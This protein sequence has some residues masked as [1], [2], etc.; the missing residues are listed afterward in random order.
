MSVIERDQTGI[1]A[2]GLTKSYGSV[3]AVRG[4]DL[5]IAP[6]ETVALLGP[7]G[8]GKTTTIDMMLGLTRPDA[9]EVAVFGVPPATAVRSGW[10]GGM[11]QIGSLPDHLRVRELVSLVASYYPHPLRVDDVLALTGSATSRSAGRGSYPVG[12]PSGAL[13]RTALVANS[14]S[15]G[16]RRADRGHRRR[17]PHRVLAG[18]AGGRRAKGKTIVFATHYLEEADAFADRIVL[19]ARGRIVADGSRP[20]R[21][22]RRSAPE[23][24]GRRCRA[25]TSSRCAPCRV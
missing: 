17:G 24:S 11:L 18:H 15:L 8:A 19:M 20:P 14:R 4:I 7:N 13:C 3:Q 10:V 9:G 23:R 2:N 12:K 22:R 21:S 1:R 6:G 16:P 25:S 5:L